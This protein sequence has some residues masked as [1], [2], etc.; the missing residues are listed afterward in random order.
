MTVENPSM[1]TSQAYNDCV[2]QYFQFTKSP[3]YC[4]GG[5]GDLWNFAFY[6]NLMYHQRLYTTKPADVKW[7]NNVAKIIPPEQSLC[8]SGELKIIIQLQGA[9]VTY[10]YFL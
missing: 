10:Y 1:H 3:V 6:L 7:M 9:G 5:A 2:Y 4:R 8:R